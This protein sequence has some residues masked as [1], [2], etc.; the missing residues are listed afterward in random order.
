MGTPRFSLRVSARRVLLFPEQ[1]EGHE[2]FSVLRRK[3]I[4]AGI[5]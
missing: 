5:D 3:D 4:S 2:L 1:G